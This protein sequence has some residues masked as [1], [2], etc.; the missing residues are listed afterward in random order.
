MAQ[1]VEICTCSKVR[2]ADQTPT[3]LKLDPLLLVANLLSIGA[4]Q[5]HFK[6][7][8]QFPT[9]GA[10]LRTIT[11][12][13]M[14][15]NS[16]GPKLRSRTGCARCRKRRQKCDELQP[17]CNRCSEAGSSCYYQ[18]KQP[19]CIASSV[20]AIQEGA[21]ATSREPAP[22][23]TGL[24]G[25]GD[26]VSSMDSHQR[27]FLTYFLEEASAAISCHES[28]KFDTCRAIMS[29]GSLNPCLLYSALAFSAMHK[30]SLMKESSHSREL[31]VHILALQSTTLS[32]LQ[33]EL[34]RGARS[35]H[36]II[37]ATALMLAT[38]DLRYNQKL[39]AWRVHFESMRQLI[40][41]D[42]SGKGFQSKDEAFSRFVQGR[43]MIMEFLLSLPPICARR[44]RL[45]LSQDHQVL[46]PTVGSIGIINGV[47][48]CCT[49]LLEVF[50]WITT[51]M[52]QQT[53]H[54]NSNSSQTSSRD[55]LLDTAA[56][57]V[58][59]VREM[60]ARDRLKPPIVSPDLSRWLTES[61]L[62]EY[63]VCNTVAQ[64]LALICIYRHLLE[65]ERS[66]TRVKES[67]H[68]I[69]RLA[70]GLPKHCGLSPAIG[71]TTSLF[72]AGCAAENEH[73]DQISALLEVQYHTTR[74]RNTYRA[75]QVLQKVWILG[76]VMDDGES[77]KVN[78]GWKPPGLC[79]FGEYGMVCDATVGLLEDFIPY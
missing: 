66:S 27:S 59:I 61:Q 25:Y 74:S 65:I 23:N 49:D 70:D 64:H 67:V 54:Q 63:H 13:L 62:N 71:L 52:D 11:C 10:A 4:R 32:T 69:I 24:H 28:I 40:G 39:G 43:F 41:P 36:G 18:P 73:R 15:L 56:S 72:V 8:A 5:M 57:L 26:V 47:M 35:D 14:V 2:R 29:A 7:S 1:G 37:L 31:E 30:A 58:S 60:M 51:L 44:Q 12:P 45:H 33:S 78:I 48:A 6:F 17:T 38:S 50:R 55:Y 21:Y 77:Q 68:S 3:K 34:Q 19:S 42:I 75:L 76:S 9:T 46:L 20:C 53:W 22:S 16:R 79:T